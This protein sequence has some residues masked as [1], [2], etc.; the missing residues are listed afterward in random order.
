[1]E[2]QLHLSNHPSFVHI[3]IRSNRNPNIHLLLL[4]EL[5]SNIVSSYHK[6][7]SFGLEKY[8]TAYEREKIRERKRCTYKLRS[9][10][11]KD[12]DLLVPVIHTMNRG[13]VRRHRLE[14]QRSPP[15]DGGGR[16][17]VG[18]WPCVAGKGGTRRPQQGRFRLGS[19]ARGS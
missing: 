11:N 5:R 6:E 1:M 13:M 17:A 10:H 14:A 9:S 3:F 2:K 4:H 18:W 15:A 7:T 19:L 8:R 16:E 12:V